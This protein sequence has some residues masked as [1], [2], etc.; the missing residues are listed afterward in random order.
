MDYPSLMKTFDPEKLNLRTNYHLM[1]SGIIPRPIA[2][3]T[4]ID[5]A[6]LVNLAP[7]SFYNGFGSN[8]PIVGFSPASSGRTGKSKDTLLNVRETGEFT[9][10]MVTFSMMDKM[11]ITSQ[12]FDRDVDEYIESG[13]SKRISDVV[14]PPYV[15]ESPYILECKL[16][17]I[18]DLGGKPGSGNLILGKVVRYHVSDS[19]LDNEDRISSHKLDAVGRLG[20]SSYVRVRDA[21]FE[22]NLSSG[23]GFA[24]LPEFVLNCSVLTADHLKKLASVVEIPSPDRDGLP[25]LDLQPAIEL[26]WLCRKLIDSGELVRAWQVIYKIGERYV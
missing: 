11:I 12:E 26:E 19:V 4:S 10:S 24:K 21:I 13:F 17:D 8:P 1:I 9:I 14:T 3:V 6:G 15:A 22:V 20:G 2:L 7:F 18:V 16:W 5:Q 23:I 25:S